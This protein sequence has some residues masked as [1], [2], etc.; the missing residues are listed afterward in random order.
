MAVNNSESWEPTSY[1]RNLAFVVREI[2]LSSVVVLFLLGQHAGWIPSP[3][4]QDHLDLEQAVNANSGI[5]IYNRGVLDRIEDATSDTAASV[6]AGCYIQ[7]VTDI[8]RNICRFGLEAI[9]L[10]NGT[11]P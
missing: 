10:V 6:K 3:G 1:I 8:E 11:K 2:G 5:L 9:G 7:A 4:L